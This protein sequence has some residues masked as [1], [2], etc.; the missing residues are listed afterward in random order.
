M[1]KKEEQHKHT[2]R[3]SDQGCKRKGM[4]DALREVERHA[5][6]YVERLEVGIRQQRRNCDLSIRGQEARDLLSRRP[7]TGGQV[8]L[9]KEESGGVV[10][11]YV[12]FE[13]RAFKA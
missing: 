4:G 2:P 8:N 7:N 12:D 3:A 5:L 13:A 6:L 11:I 10:E 1:C 9:S